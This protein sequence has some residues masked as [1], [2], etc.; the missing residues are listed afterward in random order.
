MR[1]LN[2]TTIDYHEITKERSTRKR[3][4]GLDFVFSLFR[5]F[6]MK[7]DAVM[8][9]FLIYGNPLKSNKKLGSNC[10]NHFAT[11]GP[12]GDSTIY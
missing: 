4:K 8:G 1:W 5:S 6:V 12:A 11:I 7:I 10:A 9:F 2:V 3:I